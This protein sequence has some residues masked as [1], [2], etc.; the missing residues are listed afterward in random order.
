[1]ASID[2]IIQREAN[3]FDP[4]TFKTG[5]FWQE[6]NSALTSTVESI[7]QEAIDQVSEVLNQVAQD[8]YTRSIMLSGDPGSGKSYVLSRLKK[9]FNSKAYFVYIDPF[10]DSDHIWRHTLRRTV[11]S[12]M[13]TPE[14]QKDSQLLL[15]LKGLSVFSDR[16]LIKKLLGERNL[17]INNF[18]SAY[19]VDIY[20]AKE[21]FGVLYDLTNPELYHL[22]CDWLRGEDLDKD[23]LKRLGVKNAIDSEFAA[24]GIL[25]NFGKISAS[26]HPIVLCFDQVESKQLS[27]GSADIQPIFTV[28]TTFHNERLKNFL[29]IISIVTNTWRQNLNRIQQSDRDRVERIILLKRISLDQAEALW[30]S[31]LAALHNQAKPKPKSL[32]YPLDRKILDLKFPGGK[33]TP[34]LALTIGEHLFREYKT[35]TVRKPDSAAP[36]ESVKPSIDYLASFRMLWLKEFEKTKQKVSR[37][38]QFSSLDLISMLRRVMTT[39]NVGNIEPKLLLSPTYSS[40]SFSFLHPTTKEKTGVVWSEEPNMTSFFRIMEAC[41]KAL[42]SDLCQTLYLIRAESVGNAKNKGYVLYSQIFS[43]SPNQRF[44]PD[45]DSLHYLTTCDRLMNSA[46][47]QEL[48]ISGKTITPNDLEDLIRQSKVLQD[49]SLLQELGL[50]SGKSRPTLP[51]QEAKDFLLNFVRVHHVIAQK[52]VIQNTKEHFPKLDQSG[53]QQVVRELRDD[54]KIRILDENA[55]EDEKIICLVPQQAVSR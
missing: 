49:C 52:T 14:G 29:I 42:Q 2:D 55:S 36:E 8:H 19:P 1:M 7:H 11:D 33:T 48:V 15:W 30:A 27:D 50:V 53:L 41:Q 6:E 25:A 46:A 16:S 43:K 18:R 28:N 44:I 12:L 3:P 40:Q 45:L 32:V 51:I 54:K 5:N 26:T 21:F 13:H 37:I 47:S 10:K 17:F 23:D 9:A 34:R 31:R 4:V 24:Q 35:G 39:L 22:A 20:Q 38:R